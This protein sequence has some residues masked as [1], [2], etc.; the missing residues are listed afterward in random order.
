VTFGGVTKEAPW[1]FTGVKRG[2]YGTKPTAHEKGS[3]AR[4][5][6]ECFGL[7]VPNPET[8]LFEELARNH[9][10]IVNQCDFDGVYLDAIDGSSILRG[11]EESWYWASKFVSEIQKHLKKPVGM[12]MSAMW[13]HF[14]QYRTRWQAWDYPRRGYKRFID[15]HAD[16]V[17]GGLLLPLHLGWWNFQ[18]FNPPQMDPTYPDVI[19]YLGAKLIGWD[20][21]ISLTGAINQE[22]LRTVPLYRRAVDILRTC[23]ELRHAGTFNETIKAKLREP[24]KE[25]SLFRDGKGAWRFRPANYDSHTAVGSESWSLSWET[26]N[27]FRKQPIKLRIEALMSA[28]S[29]DDPKNIVLADLSDPK[30]FGGK[31]RVAKGVALRLDKAPADTPESAGVLVGTNSGEVPQNAAWARYDWKFAPLRNLNNHQALGVWVEGDGLG[32]IIAIR[33]ESPHHISYGAVAD[34]YITVDFTGRRFFTLIETESDRWSDY[35]WNDGKWAYNT[36]RETIR[37]DMVESMSLMYNNLP[38]EKE[39]KCIIGPVKALP[40][41]PG[42]VKNPTLTVNG[43]TITFPVEIS[44]GSYLEFNSDKDCI[45]YGPTGEMIANVVPNGAS[46]VLREGINA[47]QLSCDQMEPAP[48]LKVVVISHGDPF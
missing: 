46:P 41:V 47:V 9:A 23:E 1:K 18:A 13:H 16:S 19:E 17:N 33:L 24:G 44:S 3:K 10:E 22:S 20:A 7:F 48:R 42:M 39:A 5:L 31:P 26:T 29:Y 25:F 21:G 11:S 28:G 27:P 12:E 6:K 37:F 2:A 34:R 14:W 38:P 32:E 36:Y 15:I 40:M 4:H 35:V 30:A 8:T 45:L 43:S